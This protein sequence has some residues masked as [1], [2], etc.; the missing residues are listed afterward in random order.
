ML[1]FLKNVRSVCKFCQQLALERTKLMK[2]GIFQELDTFRLEPSM[3]SMLLGFGSSI[4]GS[5]KKD[6]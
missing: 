3:F 4:A 5:L 2:V 1:L 6:I